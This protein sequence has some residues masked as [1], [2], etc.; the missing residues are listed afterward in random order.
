[1]VDYANLAALAKTLIEANGRTVTLLKRNTTPTT[2]GAPWEGNTGAP[3]SGT[4]GAIAVFVPARGTSFG[5]DAVAREN[6]LIDDIEQFALIASTSLPAN[7]DLN[8]YDTIDDGTHI[9]KI[10]FAGELQPGATS[11]IWEIGVKL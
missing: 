5:A 2:P 10:V 6:T 7:T 11:L 3:S 8:A 4:G 9:W 1:V